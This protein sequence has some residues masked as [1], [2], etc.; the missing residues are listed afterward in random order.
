MN[1]IVGNED[2]LQYASLLPNK[3]R[4]PKENV[5]YTLSI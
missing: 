3:R 4:T 5:K 1:V 2:A